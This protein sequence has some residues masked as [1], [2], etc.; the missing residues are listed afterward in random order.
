MS[1]WRGKKR[2]EKNKTQKINNMENIA[3]Q[4]LIRKHDELVAENIRINTEYSEKIGDI[5][6]AIELLTGEKAS[7]YIK[8]EK[9]DDENPNYIKGSFEEM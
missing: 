3:V 4:E 5:Y 2:H 1:R 9:Y 7:K 6:R 8:E